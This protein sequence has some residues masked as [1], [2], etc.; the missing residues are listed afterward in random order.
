[1]QTQKFIKKEAIKFGWVTTKANFWVL[2]GIVLLTTIVPAIPQVF[3]DLLQKNYLIWS[4]VLYLAYLIL[5]IIARVGLIKIMLG[6]AS[7]EKSGLSNLFSNFKT[8]L[9]YLGGSILYGIIVA[10]IPMLFLVLGTIFEKD[11]FIAVAIISAIPCVVWAIKFQFFS[12]LIIDKGMGIMAS[13]KKS[14]EMTKDLKWDL[15]LFSLLLIV[16]NLAGVLCLI[17]GLFATIPVTLI[18]TAFVY[19][20][21]LAQTKDTPVAIEAI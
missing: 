13:L 1:M 19:K 4:F 3:S 6:F 9:K 17:L 11:I 12:Y 18:A 16:I 20:K 7:G 14:A 2:S 10:G 15:F 5:Y 21:L 8:Y